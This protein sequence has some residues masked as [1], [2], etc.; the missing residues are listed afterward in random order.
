MNT[1]RV[2][3]PARGRSHTARGDVGALA[4]LVLENV[5]RGSPKA[6]GATLPPDVRAAIGD[7]CAHAHTER[8]PVERVIVTLKQEWAALPE[9][10]RLPRGGDHDAVLSVVISQCIL[11]FYSSLGSDG[12]DA[13]GNAPIHVKRG[14]P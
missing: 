9:M 8:I 4:A 10:S 3:G 2:D 6:T 12:A 14:E 1:E 5:R 11:A 7:L 13:P